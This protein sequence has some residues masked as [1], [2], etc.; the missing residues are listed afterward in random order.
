MYNEVVLVTVIGAGDREES[1]FYRQDQLL[2]FPEALLGTGSF[3]DLVVLDV[4]DL[5]V[6]S[7][8]ADG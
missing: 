6:D 7:P 3:D 4:D 5:G 8:T 1:T 2:L